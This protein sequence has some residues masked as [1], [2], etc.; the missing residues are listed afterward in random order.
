M[1]RRTNDHYKAMALVSH[2]ENKTQLLTFSFFFKRR[3]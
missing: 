3:H 2:A 1:A